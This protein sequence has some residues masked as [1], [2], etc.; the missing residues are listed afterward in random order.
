MVVIITIA[1]GAAMALQTICKVPV[2]CIGAAPS[3]MVKRWTQ[4]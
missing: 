1:R 2:N 4:Q 3:F